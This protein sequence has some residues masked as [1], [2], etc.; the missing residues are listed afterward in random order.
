MIALNDRNYV[1]RGVEGQGTAKGLLN[2]LVYCLNI[3]I[4][5]PHYFPKNKELH[6]RSTPF[7][8][9][10]VNMYLEDIGIEVKEV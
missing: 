8:T 7:D 3:K 9:D 6:F 1:A 10:E 4:H 5:S 2:S